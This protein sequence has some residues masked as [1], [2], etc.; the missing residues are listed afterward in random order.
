[1]T[2][3]LRASDSAQFLGI[4]PALAG[5]TPR[6]SIALLPFR[7]TRS[8]GA[9]RLDLPD[10]ALPL[11]RYA[12]AAVELVARVP[13]TDA[14]AVVV[15]TD[16]HPQHTPDGL[17]L[18]QAVTVDTLL[19]CAEG[20][21]LRVIEALC[22]TP[23]GWG[24]YDDTEPVLHPLSEIVSP[25]GATALGDVSGDQLSGAGLLSAPAGESRQVA[26]VLRGL[27]GAVGGRSASRSHDP[28]VIAASVLMED[29]PAFLESVLDAPDSLPPVAVA[30]LVW[31]LGRPPVRD[32]AIAQWATD[33]RRGIRTMEAQLAFATEGAR[34]PD[35]I[36]H[37]FLGRGA[38]PDGDRLRAALLAVRH[39]ATRAPRAARPGP[40]TVAAWLSWALGRATHAGRYLD[41]ARE[42]D[43]S[44]SLA[45]LLDT[46][47]SG[48]VL[49]EWAFRGR[50]S[51]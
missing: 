39:A 21:G 47:I 18:P 32:T 25:P 46:L 17:V 41:L 1:M 6:E 20:A 33:H 43:P 38:A 29:I 35:D 5:F 23:D 37:V 30:A 9:M 36:A 28:Q 12:A 13:A 7:G 48:A 16:E 10:A 4:V 49:P 51:E 14:L 42:I 2:T 11:T 45:L 24:R 27:D 26:R 3:V 34:V 50:R 8:D 22:V 31:C 40:L 15:Y 19:A 44:Y